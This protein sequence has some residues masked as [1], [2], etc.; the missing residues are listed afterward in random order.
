MSP[1][2]PTILFVI[3]VSLPYSEPEPM[4]AAQ[5]SSPC[6]EAALPTPV[7]ALLKE[8]FP[9][10]RPKQ[11]SDIDADNR[12]LWLEGPD[13][14]ACP[15]VAIGHFENATSLSYAFLL[16]LHSNPNGGH[17]LVIVNKELNRDS[18][19]STIL[20]HAE[21]RTFSGLVISKAEPGKYKDWEGKKY[22]QIRTDA[23]Y[24]EWIG[25]GA[26]LYYWLTDRFHK[27]QVSD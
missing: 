21:G 17:K 2:W 3:V 7:T 8:K 15:G 4:A 24:V 18:Y 12:Q 11:V 10:W 27:L 22:V 25:K 14:E 19:V 26:Q 23:L 13:A 5:S 1:T 6:D 16:V 20:D 9:E